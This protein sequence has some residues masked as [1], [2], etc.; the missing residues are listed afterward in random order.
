MRKNSS[1]TELSQ[2]NED[3]FHTQRLADQN[4]EKLITPVPMTQTGSYG[5]CSGSRSQSCLL[6]CDCTVSQNV[7]AAE[8]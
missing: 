2:F 1:N 4:I 5:I 8:G 6:L 3:L 7:N